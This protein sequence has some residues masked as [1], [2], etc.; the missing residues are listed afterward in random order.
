MYLQEGPYGIPN[1]FNGLSGLFG[2]IP[3]LKKVA[4]Y[5]AGY[6]LQIPLQSKCIKKAPLGVLLIIW[7]SFLEL[8]PAVAGACTRLSE[9]GI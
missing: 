3:T 8:S 2:K 7:C 5:S 1:T 6:L 4:A 9:P